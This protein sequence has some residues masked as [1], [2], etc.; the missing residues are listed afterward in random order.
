MAIVKMKFLRLFA[1]SA[2]REEL[3]R[4]L[5][6]LGCVQIDEP[7]DKLADPEW[8]ALVTRTESSALAEK[9]EMRALAFS[10]LA[11][12]NKYASVKKKLLAPRPEVTVEQLF[13]EEIRSSAM[14][15]AKAIA[16]QERRISAIYAEQSKLKTQILALSP[17]TELDV[18]LETVSTREVSVLFGSINAMV[19]LDVVRQELAAVTELAE[20]VPAGKDREQQYLLFVCHKNAEE[21]AL[22]VLKQYGFS[23]AA[24][25]G[26]T[27]TAAENTKRLEAELVKLE[28]QLEEVKSTIASFG[29]SREKL[30]L[31]I[32]RLDQEISREDAKTRLLSTQATFFLDGWVPVPDVK[33]LESLLGHYVC[34]WET[35][36]PK[37]EDYPS[38]PIKLK[39]NALTSPMNMVTEMYSMPAYDGIDPNPFMLPFFVLFF[40]FM[41]ADLG[42]G[43]ILTVISIIVRK[44]AKPKG[45][46]GYLFGL[47]TMVGISTAVIGFF[48]GGFFGNAIE[49]VARLLDYPTPDVS[50]LTHP[51]FSVVDEPLTVLIISMCI[52]M[53]QIITGMA[54]KAYMLIRDGHP[55]D[56]LFDVGS[57]WVVFAGVA[58][59]VL[60][61][62]WVVA[63]VG[64][65]MLV[66]TQ[67]RGSP[68]IPG[69]IIGGLGSLYNVTA[70]FGDVLSYSRLMV[71]M[72]AGSVIGNIF[73]LL[74]SMPGN[75]IIFAVIFIIGHVFNMGLNIIGTYVHTTRLQYLE[76]FGKFYKEGGRPFKPLR[77]NTKYVDIVKE[78]V[79]S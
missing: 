57:W 29:G 70:Y 59:G 76:F 33:A 32:D 65:A 14:A 13:S 69:K 22:E 56:A 44:K 43:I 63:L 77:L 79:K 54:I 53:V 48:T 5:Q 2:D 10:S 50:F 61:G 58:V 45:T 19:S 21:A 12:L 55:L 9:K 37:E 36:D 40:G 60:T 34:A 39:S 28:H 23:R 47:M 15:A 38:V 66:L 62:S 41:F 24:L 67:G 72:L 27:G 68:T 64:V 51:K 25:R 31:C 52:G 20:L 16:Q 49:T 18:P 35:E 46:M 74:G 11:A 78:E 73:N 71:M 75:I 6:N 7:T 30:K 26:W 3:L 42:Y 1:M 8:A 4:Q 17:W